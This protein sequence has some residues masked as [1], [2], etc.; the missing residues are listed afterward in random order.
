MSKLRFVRNS[1]YRELV[2]KTIGDSVKMPSEIANDSG[3]LVY[4]ISTV[5]RELSDL[6]LIVCINPNFKKGR[7]YKLTDQ[8]FRVLRWLR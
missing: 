2:L 5:L 6:N 3:I 7:M 8:G 1:T 4:H